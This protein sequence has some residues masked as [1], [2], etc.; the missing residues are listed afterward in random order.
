MESQVDKVKNESTKEKNSRPTPWL[1]IFFVT[2]TVLVVLNVL[3][4]AISDIWG[5]SD[6]GNPSSSEDTNSKKIRVKNSIDVPSVEA[7]ELDVDAITLNSTEGVGV[8]FV[9]YSGTIS[10]EKQ[11]DTY[12]FTPNIEGRY[13]FDFSNI[14]ANSKVRFQIFNSLGEKIEDTYCTNGDGVTE[15]ELVAGETY[16]LLV[17]QNTNL[18]DYTITIGQQKETIN[19]TDYTTIIDNIEFVDQKNSYLYTVPADGRLRLEVNGLQG[20]SKVRLLMWDSLNQNIVDTYCSSGDG[21][22]VTDLKTGDTYQIQISQY[23]DFSPYTLNLFGA[24]ADED[25]STYN[26]IKDSIEFVDQRNVYSF[27]APEDG[28]YRLEFTDIKYGTK[29]HLRIYDSNDQSIVDTYCEN[30]EGETIK[31]IIAGEVYEVQVVQ[32]SN[33]GDYTLNIGKQKP[34]V[35][36]D[37]STSVNDSI[38]YTDQRNV[39]ILPGEQGESY[40]VTILNM[41]ADQNIELVA[42]DELGYEMSS[43]SYVNVNGSI[44]FGPL[45]SD[46]EISIQVRQSTGLGGY[47]VVIKKQ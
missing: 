8:V 27:T 43:A 23:T 45:E 15:S 21:T 40:K 18:C 39:Y 32:Y 7:S 47:T 30:Q 28:R 14:V 26:I 22:T 41:N 13:R 35:A 33:L 42:F 4:I 20:N 10:S 11:T 29:V 24:K 1:K 44:S 5:N 46:Q 9:T 16:S 12:E 31:D 6:Y 34:A 19:L 36:V 37:G 3:K 25:I 17:M 38:Q 2:I